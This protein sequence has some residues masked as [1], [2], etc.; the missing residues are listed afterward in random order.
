MDKR[1]WYFF[2]NTSPLLMIRILIL[3][4]TS[5]LLILFTTLSLTHL[6]RDLSSSSHIYTF[7]IK[8]RHPTLLSSSIFFR[9]FY[10]SSPIEILVFI[11]FPDLT[12][13]HVDC[14][15]D[16]ALISHSQRDCRLAFGYSVDSGWNTTPLH[17]EKRL[18]WR[19]SKN[20]R[21]K[22]LDVL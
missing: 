8:H 22:D 5:S 19:R 18:L 16:P 17:E 21:L 2:N 11:T 6:L 3:S 7:T 1:C 9:T 13:K 20:H 10:Y 12:S 14:H 4:F 15:T